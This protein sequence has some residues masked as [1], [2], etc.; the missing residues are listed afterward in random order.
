MVDVTKIFDVI[1]DSVSPLVVGVIAVGFF[2][3]VVIA[4]VGYRQWFYSR[5]NMDAL[6]D[7]ERVNG[8]PVRR[9][10]LARIFVEGSV[11]K[12]QYATFFN[13]NLKTRV[14]PDN[15]T[16]I[17]QEGGRLGVHAWVDKNGRWHQVKIT[18]RVPV[19]VEFDDQGQVKNVISE[20]IVFSPVQEN[21]VEQGKI[22]LRRLW[23][24]HK[25]KS[26]WEKYG[27]LVMLII[28]FA[29]SA[30]LFLLALYFSNDNLKS[31]AGALSNAAAQCAEQYK[32]VQAVAG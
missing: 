24:R 14:A 17:S 26:M 10:A 4:C 18:K 3:F 19:E 16:L 29:F 15:D 30:F 5:Y 1:K 13:W 21:D 7:I 25:D 12:I 8:V 22:E 31:T 9:K 27:P 32:I 11:R 28:A 20:M 6:I 23:N 2:F